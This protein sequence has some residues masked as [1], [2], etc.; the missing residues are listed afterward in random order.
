MGV[1]GVDSHESDIVDLAGV[2]IQGGLPDANGV[3]VP[4]G[5]AERHGLG[6]GDVI[7]VS[8]LELEV[9]GVFSEEALN[10]LKDLDGS[11]YSPDKWV[12]TNPEGEMPHWI[13]EDCEGSEVLIMN[14]ETAVELS[15]VGIQRIATVL[16]G[17]VDA[18]GFAERLALERGYRAYASMPDSYVTFRLGNY[19]EGRG[20]SLVIPWAIVVLNVVITM[21]NSLYERKGEIEIL[22]SVGLNPAQVSAIFVAEASI[23]GFVAGGLGYLIGL[24]LYRGMSYLNIGLQVHQKVSAIWSVASITLAVSAVL[25]GAY[26]ALRNSVVI[27]PSLMRRWKIDRDSGGFQE[28]Y[29]IMIP[30]KLE[31]EEIDSYIEFIHRRLNRLENHPVQITSSIKV[32]GSGEGKRMRFIYKTAQASTGNFYTRNELK[33][34]RLP[35]GEYGAALESLGDPSWVHVTGS[36]IR[37]LTMEYSTKDRG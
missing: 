36:L 21:L 22:S 7:T 3:L 16:R 29:R 31:A 26:T 33:I 12:N 37:R 20:L 35:S 17:G 2:L 11:G 19:F 34:T 27:T 10:G 18:E 1:V 14:T 15:M 24:S 23:T 30:L 25:A 6:I 28:A 4:S 5:V 8:I 13:V 9:Q 32:E